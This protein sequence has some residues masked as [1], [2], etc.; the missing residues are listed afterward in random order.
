MTEVVGIRVGQIIPN[1]HDNG[2]GDGYSLAGF[3]GTT[4]ANVW[5]GP[6]G[7]RISAL[8][9]DGDTLRIALYGDLRLGS[10]RYVI[11]IDS[12]ETYVLEWP[13]DAPNPPPHN[14]PAMIAKRHAQ[15]IS[16]VGNDGG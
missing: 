11:P 3:G 6:V 15:A 12:Q 9:F 7:T 5:S 8:Q 16:R 4:G 1:R 2:R 14:L 10:S 13:A